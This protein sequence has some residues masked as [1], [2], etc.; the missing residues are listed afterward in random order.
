M[1]DR[2][3]Y[4]RVARLEYLIQN[5]YAHNNV[6]MPEGM[7]NLGTLSAAVQA[8]L[9]QGNTIGAIKQYRAETGA[10]LAEAKAAIE[11]TLGT[12]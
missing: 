8:E 11:G 7:P 6:T 9:A 4:Q 2:E 3:L 1:S 12:G 5:L 10:G